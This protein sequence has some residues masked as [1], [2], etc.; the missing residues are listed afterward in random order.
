M[1]IRANSR[2][3]GGGRVRRNSVV[4]GAQPRPGGGHSARP[5]RPVAERPVQAGAAPAGHAPHHQGELLFVRVVGRVWLWV[6]GDTRVGALGKVQ[7][8]R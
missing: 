3:Q 2:W 4:A 7:R 1:Q 5:A 8:T 6:A